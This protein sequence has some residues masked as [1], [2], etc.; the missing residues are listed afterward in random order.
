MSQDQKKEADTAT[1]TVGGQVPEELF[2]RFKMTY[3]SRKESA[4]T[5]LIHALNLYIDA[6]PELNEDN[7]EVK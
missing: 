7:K 1:K 5:A 4:V 6:V 2:W 3:A